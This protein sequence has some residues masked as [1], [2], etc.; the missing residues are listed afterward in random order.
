MQ[1]AKF[2][3]ALLMVFPATV[4][5]QSANSD[6]SAKTQK[7]IEQFRQKLGGEEKLK[8]V[9]SLSLNGK[10]R[11]VTRTGETTGELKLDL[12][13]PDKLLRTEKS[14]PK[15]LTTVTVMQ[16][17]N[18]DHAW[19]D[20]SVIRASGDD[21]AINP[22]P[23]PL[24]SGTTI[25]TGTMGM[26][27]AATGTTSVRS[28]SPTGNVTTERSVLG[29][30]IPNSANGRPPNDTLEKLDKERRASGEAK[31]ADNRPRPPNTNT[32]NAALEKRLKKELT[33]LHLIWLAAAPETYPLQF[34]FAETLPTANGSV[35]AIEIT[36]TDE[37]AARLFLDQRTMLPSMISYRDFVFPSA[38]YVVSASAD[39]VPTEAQ[40]IAVQLLFSDYRSVNGVMLPHQIVKAVNGA[41]VSEWKIE[42]YKLNP[43]LKPKRFE[44]K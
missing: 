26:R 39:A 21:G 16:A 7:L 23:D 25:S 3:L 22:N 28:T 6:Q 17:L 27:G 15:N 43:D 20:N 13:L 9:R 30:N 14:D 11:N 33:A 31:P 5:A 10:Y 41:M 38:G 18:G 36:G 29:M 42:K 12:L 4:F 1:P 32:A 19:A 8:S 37:F 24:A 34:S 40:E 2:A 44:K 35:E